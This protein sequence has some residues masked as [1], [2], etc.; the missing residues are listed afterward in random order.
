MGPMAATCEVSLEPLAST[1]FLNS[2][3]ISKLKA[4]VV[5]IVVLLRCAVL[6]CAPAFLLCLHFGPGRE[7]YNNSHLKTA[8]PSRVIGQVQ[9][10][11]HGDP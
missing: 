10:W 9:S 2:T 1:P 11:K 5:F 4:K 7:F 8:D 3:Q 6:N